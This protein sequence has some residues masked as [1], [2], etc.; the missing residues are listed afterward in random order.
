VKCE[1]LDGSEAAEFTSRFVTEL[2]REISRLLLN[3]PI[4]E[5]RKREGKPAAN[6][7]LLR[8]CGIFID[9]FLAPH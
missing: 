4:N 6:C 1:P 2:S 3:H 9:V 8:G 5:A 7:V